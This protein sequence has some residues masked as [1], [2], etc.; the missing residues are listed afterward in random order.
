[1][2]ISWIPLQC[3]ECGTEWESAPNALPTPESE[4]GCP[5]C[6]VSQPVE[7]LVQSRNG[8]KLLETFHEP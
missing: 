7:T 2:T 8:M 4:F 5:Y 3:A 1:M 6:G